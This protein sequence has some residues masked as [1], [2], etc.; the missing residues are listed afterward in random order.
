MV[1][2]SNITVKGKPNWAVVA[3]FAALTSACAPTELYP[4]LPP[5]TAEQFEFATMRSSNI[6]PKS[7]PAAFEKAF[8][9]FC[10]NGGSSFAS[11]A[12][13]LRN[14]DYIAVPKKIS[15]NQ[16]AFVVDDARP[17]IVVSDDGR[18]CAT[19]A[20]SRTGQTAR[21]QGF[22]AARFPKATDIAQNNA[23]YEMMKATNG[24]P[25]GLIAMYRMPS[26]TEGSRLAIAIHRSN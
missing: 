19:V 23:K 12:A 17:M 20:Q 16:T 26:A 8:N 15:P 1:N 6:V 22:V 21:L 4:P 14:A 3:G 25:Q 13:K 2:R 18:F 5:R 10:L 7:S 11:M 9:S 24:N